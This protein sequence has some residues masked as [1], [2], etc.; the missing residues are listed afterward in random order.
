MRHQVA[1]V[2]AVRRAATA[3]GARSCVEC[4]QRRTGGVRPPRRCCRCDNSAVYCAMSWPQVLADR[5][6]NLYNKEA[7]VVY[8]LQRARDERF[9]PA[10]SH[11]RGLRQVCTSARQGWWCELPSGVSGD[12]A[13][14]AHDV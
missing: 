6:G 14:A 7:L 11:I 5:V 9:I 1:P 8:L 2:H 10:L 4:L 13:A 12:S 3:T